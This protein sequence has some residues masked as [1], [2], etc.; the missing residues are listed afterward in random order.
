MGNLYPHRH[1]THYQEKTHRQRQ[2]YRFSITIPVF[3]EF[4]ASDEHSRATIVVSNS[5]DVSANGLRVITD[6]EL[7]IGS[8]LRTCVQAPNT[9]QGFILITDVK[10]Q[11]DWKNPGEFL[12]GLAIF[13]SEDSS[14]QEWKEF[15][16]QLGSEELK[17][18]ENQ[19]RELCT[20]DSLGRALRLY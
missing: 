10:W 5:I 6:R 3:L 15:I 7:P 1:A 12:V 17:R 13:E 19:F 14:I 11:A 8:I 20:G 4:D 18:N 9:A 2:E 16:A